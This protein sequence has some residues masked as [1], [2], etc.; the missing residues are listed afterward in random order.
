ME[1]EKQVREKKTEVIS[2]NYL[3]KIPL[4]NELFS[5]SA[6]ENGAVTLDIE[7]KG[8]VNRIAQKL[9]K[10]PRISH[11]H[12]DEMGSFIWPLI[13]GEK[14]IADIGIP[15]KEHFGEKAEPLYERLAKYFQILESYSFITW[16]EDDETSA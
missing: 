10:K 14:S 4:R 5:W 11:V 7:N 13:D 9:L 1:E 8:I 15:V 6:D 12:L 16:A 2:R 3:D